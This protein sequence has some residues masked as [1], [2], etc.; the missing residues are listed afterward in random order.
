[1]RAQNAPALVVPACQ[2]RG[3]PRR[4]RAT[5]AEVGRAASAAE[6]AASAAAALY[7]IRLLDSRGEE[8]PR[9]L[10][11]L[12]H[13]AQLRIKHGNASAVRTRALRMGGC[14]PQL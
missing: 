12:R 7:A 14:R 8:R 3:L 5:A 10:D 6:G 13:R 1:M 2:A 9:P 11:E 4:Q